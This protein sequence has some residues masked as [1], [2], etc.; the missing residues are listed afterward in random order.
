MEEC[1]LIQWFYRNLIELTNGRWTS[2]LL[3]KLAQSR[4]S[5]L[6][7]PSFAKIYKVNVHEMATPIEEFAT[8][9]DFFIRKLKIGARTIDARVNS[10]VS[11]VDAVLEDIGSISTELTLTVKGKQYS[12]L[13]MLGSDDKARKYMNGTYFLLYLSPSHYHRIHSPLSGKVVG[14]WTLGKKSYPVNR[15]GLKYGR[16]T[17]AKNYRKITEVEHDSGVAAIVKVGAMFV[18]SIE[19]IHMGEQLEKGEEI[20]YFT[21]GST[22]ILLFNPDSIEPVQNHVTPREVRVGDVL[23]YMRS[24][25]N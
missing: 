24:K 6:F 25:Q 4:A 3:K 7:I 15:H 8:L 18:N 1:D 5:R 19:S 23:G 2:F 9:H 13:E 17:L 20:A 11:P 21:F 14:E 10:I 16:D 12:V 22:V